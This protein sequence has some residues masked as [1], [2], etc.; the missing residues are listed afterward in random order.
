MNLSK[1]LLAIFAAMA[2]AL[3]LTLAACNNDNGDEPPAQQDPVVTDDT[4]GGD[5]NTNDEQNDNN[6]DNSEDDFVNEP[7]VDFAVMAFNQREF[8]IPA[9]M[10]INIGGN[11][12]PGSGEGGGASDAIRI[13]GFQGYRE[14]DGGFPDGL[15]STW[16][17]LISQNGEFWENVERI[18]AEFYFEGVGGIESEAISNVEVFMQGG[19]L[20][21]HDWWNTGD[22]LLKQFDEDNGGDGFHWGDRMTAVWDIPFYVE[23][24]VENV[25]RDRELFSSPPVPKDPEDEESDKEGGGILKF[26]LQVKTDSPVNDITARIIW[27]DVTIYVYDLDL[28]NEFVAEVTATTGIEMSPGA[29]DRV[30]QVDAQ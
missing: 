23:H 30:V 16:Q 3:T 27:T 22:N 20:W 28:F 1:R 10:N 2:M 7:F 29:I 19:A 8:T 14:P 12:G 5:D 18:E 6:D 4:A 25:G 15:D 26:G 21:S 17:D 9:G 11:N 24:R 13:V